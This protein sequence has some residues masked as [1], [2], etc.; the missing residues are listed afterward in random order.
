M[1]LRFHRRQLLATGVM[2]ALLPQTLNAAPERGPGLAVTVDDFDLSDTP[3]MSGEVRDLAIRTAL[4]RHGV[5]AAGFVAGKYV[6]TDGSPRVLT[7]W[8]QEGHILGNHSFSHAYYAG[9]DPEG[10]IAD[11]LKCEALLTPYA[12]FR[13]LFRYPFLA[14]GKSAAGRDEFRMLLH[15][16]GYR[17]APVT[18][19]TSDWYVDERLR[20]RLKTDP[21]T[22]V[23]GYRRYWLDHLWERATYYDGLAQEV[24]GHSLDHTIL[25]HHRLATGLFLDDALTMFRSRGWRLVDA[26]AAFE[27]PDLKREYST[28]PSGQSLVWAAAKANGGFAGRLRYPG[29][30][31]TY[32]KPTMDAL[33]L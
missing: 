24:L 28:L 31:E 5:K 3:L 23:S 29:E 8:S 33:S 2:A 27:Q 26:S 13:R 7:A 4:R 6:D 22:D 18:I 12:G 16:H 11:V 25:L 9:A 20:A 19:D 1:S 10:E 30:D 32:E 15:D 17:I 14:E 21:K